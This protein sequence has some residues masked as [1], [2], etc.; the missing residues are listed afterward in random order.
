MERR[1]V[2]WRGHKE[3]TQECRHVESRVSDIKR[4]DEIEETWIYREI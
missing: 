2:D 4:D 3:A 1:Q